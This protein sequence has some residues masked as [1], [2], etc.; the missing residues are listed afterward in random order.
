MT[1]ASIQ[2]EPH[3]ACDICGRGHPTH[4]CQASTEEVNVVENYT[5]NAMGQRNLGFAWSS[6]GGT[7]N[8]WQQNNS[9][10][11]GQGAPAFQNQQRQQ[12]QPQQPIQPGIKD[13]IIS[14]ESSWNPLRQ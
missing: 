14:G 9:R 5:F 8:A 3:A 1:L 12:L 10:P 2:S 6:P 7:T 11:P 4:E 13:L